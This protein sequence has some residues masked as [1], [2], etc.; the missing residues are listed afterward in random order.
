VVAE[1]VELSEEVEVLEEVDL[2]VVDEVPEEVDLL[3]EV[4]L[5]VVDEEVGWE[6]L[7]KLGMDPHHLQAD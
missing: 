3:E 7:F 1:E 2:P 5:P 4:E 6:P